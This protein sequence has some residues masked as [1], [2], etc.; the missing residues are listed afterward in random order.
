MNLNEEVHRIK[1]IM[2]VINEDVE[3]TEQLFSEYLGNDKSLWNVY[4]D[5]AKTLKDSFTIEHFLME[6]KYSGGLKSLAG[7]IL[8]QTQKAYDKLNKVVGGGLGITSGYRS[9]QRQGEIFIQMANKYGGTISG[10]L[11]QAALPGFSEH[12]TGRALDISGYDKVNETLLKKYGFVRNYLKPIDNFRIAEPWH[13]YYTG[14][15]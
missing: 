14:D 4:L 13:I 10:G 11:K 8:P 7:G 5:I 6:Y 15:L 2:G 3:K 9:Y 1:S 12:H